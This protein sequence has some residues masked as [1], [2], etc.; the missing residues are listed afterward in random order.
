MGLP[1]I[2]KHMEELSGLSAGDLLRYD[3]SGIAKAIAGTDYVTPSGIA[4]VGSVSG[5]GY[6]VKFADG[7][8]LQWN[9]SQYSGYTTD[10]AYGTLYY[11]TLTG[12]TFPVA[13]ASTPHTLVSSVNSNWYISSSIESYTATSTG[14]VF[15]YGVAK[16]NANFSLSWL[17]VGRWK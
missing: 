7:T 4:A 12:F 17:A 3:G 10:I 11:T 2:L 8:L 1:K 14:R 5:R 16:H 13:F 15:I 9:K 6:Y